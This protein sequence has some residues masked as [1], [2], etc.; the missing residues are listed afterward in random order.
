L[1]DLDQILASLEPVL[2]DEEYVFASVGVDEARALEAQATIHEAEGV[3]VV[4]RR[5]HADS[6]GVQYEFVARWITLTVNSSLEAV[7]LTAAFAR[8]LGD[9][10]ISCNVLAAVHHDHILVPAADAQRALAALRSLAA[11]G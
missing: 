5:D 4:V 9:A 10:G 11:P 8:A 2:R 6:A 3:T 7:G 1:T